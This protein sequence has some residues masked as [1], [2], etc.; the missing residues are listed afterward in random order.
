MALLQH[1]SPSRASE[2]ARANRHRLEIDGLRAL[3]VTLVVVHHVFTGRVS[4]GVDVFLVL[5]GFFLALT[6]TRQ[7]ERTGRLSVLA[8]LSRTL[9]RLLPPALVVLS[10]T[11]LASVLLLPQTRWRGIADHLLSSVTFTENQ[12]LVRE[13]VDY[14]ANHGATSPIQ[15]F[16]SL[17]IQL[18]VLLLAPVVVAAG[19]AVLRR[20]PLRRCARA[21][22]VAVV[23]ALTAAS[24]GWSV[25]ST[26]V[27][28]RSAYF[29]TLPR[30]WELGVGALV[31]LLLAGARPRR[32]LATALGWGGVLALVACGVALDG[33]HR[34]PGWQ[35]AWPVLCAVAVLV[36]GDGGGV[37][38]VHRPLSLPAVQW[39]GRVSYPLYLWH[40]PVLV[41]YLEHTGRQSASLIG[42][43]AVIVGSMVLAAAT[44]HVVGTAVTTRLRSWRPTRT[45]AVLTACTV[46]LAGFSL[47]TTTWLDRQAAAVDAAHDDRAYPGALA[48]VEEPDTASAGTGVDP[49]PSLAVV[50]GD[51]ARLPDAKCTVETTPGTPVPAQTEVCV[52]GPD[53]PTKRI[54]VVG[55]SHATQWLV[56]VAALARKHSWQVVSMVRPG[57][58]LSTGSEY[59]PPG[60]PGYDECAAWR[61]QLVG[62]IIALHPDLVIS[63]GTRTDSGSEEV[64]PPGFVAAWQQLSDA[65]LQVI[66]MRDNPR[67]PD[68]SP[69]CTERWGATA[70][71]CTVERNTVYSDDLLERTAPTLP[72]GIR[73][74]DTSSFFCGKTACPPLIGNVRVYLDD[75]HVTASYM[76]TITPLLEPALHALAGWGP[77][78]DASGASAG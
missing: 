25:V 1:S 31:A 44:H 35:A 14:A 41:L 37:F 73:L 7:I 5:S 42:G 60:A 23:V 62:R 68:D 77:A 30:L 56:P 39:L 69:D 47:V 24:F 61:S 33:A 71:Q 8:T 20:S 78:P 70:P 49:L 16:W 59:F 15:H 46:P 45:V 50:H 63:L 38:G 4:G 3:A 58:N 36:A 26:E 57:C 55:D 27:D 13:A 22:V 21:T 11:A 74:L 12:R 66:G 19:A 32:G 28:Q 67:H 51:W 72:A 76:R 9:S 17:S 2:P 6:S 75:S 29:A 34:F 48:L 40:W 53:Q 65:G 54:V 64:V 43:P 10:G 52:E 18:Q